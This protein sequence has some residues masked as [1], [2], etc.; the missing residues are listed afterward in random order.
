MIYKPEKKFFPYQIA[1]SYNWLK[2]TIWM[3]VPDC[4]VLSLCL[5]IITKKKTPSPIFYEYLFIHF[6]L[7]FFTYISFPPEPAT[8]IYEQLRC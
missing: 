7:V 8:A 1:A 2:G 3:F 4:C 5:V 6:L